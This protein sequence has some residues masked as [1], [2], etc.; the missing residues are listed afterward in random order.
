[1]IPGLTMTVYGGESI[2]RAA[3][4]AQRIADATDRAVGFTFNSVRCVAQPKG[5]A[6][7]LIEMQQ[8][9]QRSQLVVYSDESKISVE[10]SRGDA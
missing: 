2:E 4:E 7:R 6:K 8:E 1:M 9:A 10:L 5:D 3:K